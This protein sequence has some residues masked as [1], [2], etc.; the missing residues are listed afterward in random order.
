MG[1]PVLILNFKIAPA[2]N[3]RG[4]IEIRRGREG[5]HQAG[6]KGVRSRQGRGHQE[7]VGD[8][9]RGREEEERLRGG[10]GERADSGD[11]GSQLCTMFSKLFQRKSS[12]SSTL[13]PVRPAATLAATVAAVGLLILRH[14]SKKGRKGGRRGPRSPLGLLSLDKRDRL[15]GRR[16]IKWRNI[17]E[18]S[19]LP[20]YFPPLTLFLAPQVNSQLMEAIQQKVELAQQLEEW[21]TDMEQLLEEQIRDRLAHS[22][23]KSRRRKSSQGGGFGVDTRNQQQQQ[24]RR[25]RR[26]PLSH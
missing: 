13:S 8:E 18:S 2:F 25:R 11:A 21:K 15:R 26:A 4:P 20:Q 12:F 10:T 23:E 1:H 17:N 3:N 7:G 22:E 14:I 16:I 24:G 5:Y 9:R 19:V 6:P